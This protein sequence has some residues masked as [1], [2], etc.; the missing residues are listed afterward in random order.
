[1][2]FTS[3][4]SFSSSSWVFLMTKTSSSPGVFSLICASFVLGVSNIA[5]D[6]GGGGV[7]VSLIVVVFFFMASFHK[8]RTFFET[9]FFAAVE[10]AAV[11]FLL[12]PS[13]LALFDII[14]IFDAS[15]CFFGFGLSV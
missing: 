13:K 10:A 8:P 9:P 15:T 4:S 12:A 14:I 6:R 11:P 7:F 2:R 3:F 1:M 5:P